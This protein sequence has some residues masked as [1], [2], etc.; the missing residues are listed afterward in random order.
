MGA[1]SSS[2]GSGRDKRIRHVDHDC[3]RSRIAAEAACSIG[4]ADEGEAA[5]TTPSAV[6]VAAV[7]AAVPPAPPLQEGP[8][9]EAPVP[10]VAFAVFLGSVFGGV[11]AVA[12]P[13]GP[14]T[15]GVP[16]TVIVSA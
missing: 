16:T 4:G 7:A 5:C 6:L 11:V 1:A 15:P 14:S 12:G 10:P 2:I 8:E 9:A 13:P 3:I